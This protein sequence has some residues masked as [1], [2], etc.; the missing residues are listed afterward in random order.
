[1]DKSVI[2]VGR[3]ERQ[4]FWRY[5]IEKAEQAGISVRRYCVAQG[6]C[7]ASFYYWR[8]KFLRDGRA[9]AVVQSSRFTR[10]QVSGESSPVRMMLGQDVVLCFDREPEVA[11]LRELVTEL[12]G[13]S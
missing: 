9:P 2:P 8:Q 3:E 6:L 13:R 4:K 12:R 10:I 7:E 1:M 11:W 5:H